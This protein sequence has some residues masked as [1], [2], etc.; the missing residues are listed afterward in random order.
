[1]LL[2]EALT[3]LYAACANYPKPESLDDSYGPLEPEVAARVLNGSLTSLSPRDADSLF[4]VL[5]GDEPAFAYFFPR[6]VDLALRF[7]SPFHYPDLP[8]VLERARRQRLLVV[9]EVRRATHDL[10]DALWELLFATALTAENIENIVRAS[11]WIADSLQLRLDQ[12]STSDHP[13]GQGNLSAYILYNLD[14]MRSRRR[15]RNDQEWRDRPQQEIEIGIWLRSTDLMTRIC[16]L[17]RSTGEPALIET[18]ARLRD[19]H[20]APTFP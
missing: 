4:M 19:L 2:P 7:E 20:T 13:N 6:L 18:C 3:Q 9:P 1:M 10:V 14:S 16:Q 12:W 8:A 5:L 17:A 15:L 11:A